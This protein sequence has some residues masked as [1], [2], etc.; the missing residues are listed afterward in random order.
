MRTSIN[1][2]SS[3]VVILDVGVIV[4]NSCFESND[5]SILTNIDGGIP[6]STGNPYLIS[7]N[8]PNGFTATSAN[9]SNLEAGSYT[10]KIED[11]SGFSIT[12]ELKITQPDVLSITKDGEKNISC[13]QGND[14]EIAVTIDG[15]I[16]PYTYN[17]STVDGSG[18]IPNIK[19]QNTLTAGTYA[20]EIIDKNNCTIA[21]SFILSE[22][23]GLKIETVSKR[24]VLCF[25][26]ATG[27]IEIKVS[28]GTKIETSPGVFD[29]L[30]NWSGPNGFTST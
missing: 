28:G 26:D 30:Y 8:G 14:G 25:G 13:F 10:L 4:H 20:L 9:I 18:I 15:G 24:D 27:A 23:E 3:S 16:L 12:E 29:Y 19:N 1:N 17:W 2:I 21:T 6:F 11:N 7:W 22:P 5:G